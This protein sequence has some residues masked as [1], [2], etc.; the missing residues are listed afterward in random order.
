MYQQVYDPVSNSLGFRSIF[1]AI[2]LLTLFVLLGG[3]KMKAHWAASSRSRVALIVAIAVYG[4]PF[5]QTLD[6]G[7][8]RRGL[9]AV[10]DHVDRR[11]RDLDLHDDRQDRRLRRAAAVVRLDLDDQRIQAVIIAFSF[12]AL[13]EA[14][15]GFGTPVAICSVMLIALG[16]KPIKAAA[17]AL[18]ADTAPVAFGAIAIPITT[19]SQITGI[20]KQDLGSMVGRQT[21]LLALIVPLILVY[22]VD[23]RRGLRQTWPAAMVAGSVFAVGQFVCSNY[24]S[25]E[26]ADIVASLASIAAIVGSPARLAAVR[27]AR[28]GER[29]AAACPLWP[30]PRSPTRSSSERPGAAAHGPKDSRG[31]GAAL[32]LAVPD[33]HRRA[34]AR[35]GGPDQGLPDKAAR[36]CSPGPACT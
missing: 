33:H 22:I 2:P 6:S 13:L 18:V 34:R 8:R 9:R 7:A 17:V 20:S 19:L 16:F 35:A 32:V 10:P 28:R 23:G 27:A 4:M 14:L 29:A 30:A 3:L 12:G 21:P 15:A 26:L 31:G 11:E 36:R 25:V 5:G 1:A 24:I